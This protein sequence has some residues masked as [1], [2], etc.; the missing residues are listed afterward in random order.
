MPIDIDVQSFAELNNNVTDINNKVTPIQNMALNDVPA[1]S[2]NKISVRRGTVWNIEGE[3]VYNGQYQELG[4][5]SGEV[6]LELNM[7][8]SR[9]AV[10]ATITGYTFVTS[11]GA[12]MLTSHVYTIF[13]KQNSTGN[14]S[15]RWPYGASVLNMVG[16]DPNQI[17]AV[18]V[19]KLPNGKIF[20]KCE[21]FQGTV[22]IGS[23]I[24]EFEVP[25]I[26]FPDSNQA[27]MT[28][29][30]LK[31][32]AVAHGGS[33]DNLYSDWEIADDVLYTNLLFS[34]YGNTIDLYSIQVVL[35]QAG[36]IY[37][38]TRYGGDI[39]G[40]P[41]VSPWDEHACEVSGIDGDRYWDQ[42]VL[43]INADKY[44]WEGSRKIVDEKGW[45]TI[46]VLGDT[47][48]T[49]A[50]EKWAI[51]FDGS[52]DKLNVAD[53]A[54]INPTTQDFTLELFFS[55]SVVSSTILTIKAT[56]TGHRPYNISL[57]ATT[58]EIKISF[59]STTP[60]IYEVKSGV[61]PVVGKIYHV[62][63]VRSGSIFKIFVDGILKN[64]ATYAITLYSHSGPLQVGAT[65]DGLYPFNGKIYGMRFTNGI[66]RYS[67]DFQVDLTYPYFKTGNLW[68]TPELKEIATDNFV[69]KDD[70]EKT[71]LLINGNVG[72]VRDEASSRA[73]TLNGNA[74]LATENN[75]SYISFDGA[76]DFLTTPVGNDFSFNGDFTVE[77]FIRVTTNTNVP[78]FFI[79][80]SAASNNNRIMFGYYEGGW[81]IYANTTSVVWDANPSAPALTTDTIHHVALSRHS[82][83]FTVYVDGISVGTYTSAANAPSFAG[84]LLYIGRMRQANTLKDLNGRI[85]SYRISDF[86]RYTAN[87]TP[88]LTRPYF[89]TKPKVENWAE[90]SLLINALDL[91]VGSTD[92]RDS[93]GNAISLYGDTKVAKDTNGLEY[94]N[95]D[96]AGDYLAGT[97]PSLGAGLFTLEFFAFCKGASG[98][99][100]FDSR[101]SDLDTS[102]FSFYFRGTSNKITFGTSVGSTWTA[103]EGTVVFTAN[104]LYH[105]AVCRIDSTNFRVYVNGVL[106]N[107]FTFS[108]SFTRTSAR[109]G[110]NCNASADSGGAIYGAR[111]TVGKALYTSNFN[112]DLTN[113][114]FP[115]YDNALEDL[116]IDGNDYSKMTLATGVSKIVDKSGNR[117]E[118]IQNTA[119]S[120]PA[121]VQ[122]AQNG[123][124]AL[125]FDGVDDSLVVSSSNVFSGKTLGIFFV[126]KWSGTDQDI[127]SIH[128]GGNTAVLLESSN[129]S[130]RF[131]Y[132]NPPGIVG[133]I[134]IQSSTGTVPYG[135]V[136][137]GFARVSVSG[138]QLYMDEVLVAS[139]AAGVNF[140]SD[141]T[142]TLGFLGS[143][144]IRYLNGQ[145]LE[146]SFIPNLSDFWWKRVSGYLAHKWGLTDNLPDNHPYKTG[147]PM[148]DSRTDDYWY[149]TVLRINGTD[150]IR[151]T[152]IVDSSRYNKIT[153]Y[154]TLTV[155]VDASNRPYINFNG[156]WNAIYFPAHLYGFGASDFTI[157]M[158]V[159]FSGWNANASRLWNTNGDIYSGIDFSVDGSGGLCCYSS[160]TGSTWDVV[161]NAGFCQLSLN[162]LYHIAAVR[163]GTY[164][165]MFVNGTKYV[166][167]ATL[168]ATVLYTNTGNKS[169]GGQSPSYNR[170]LNGKL[171]SA[172]V[173]KGI[174]RYTENFEVDLTNP[175]FPNKTDSLVNVFDPFDDS[176]AIAYYL[177]QVDANDL[178][179]V[180]NGTPT[181]VNFSGTSATFDNLSLNN[182]IGV[183]AK[184]INNTD[185]YSISAWLRMD[186]GDFGG[187]FCQNTMGWNRYGIELLT[188]DGNVAFTHCRSDAVADN[189][190][191]FA[192]YDVDS[193]FH[194]FVATRN[195]LNIKIYKDGVLTQTNTL[196]H[197]T[198]ANYANAYIGQYV[199]GNNN[200]PQGIKTLKYLRLFNRELLAEEV[201]NLYSKEVGR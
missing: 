168:G 77:C 164:L 111:L 119:A 121:L 132:R 174:A 107:S 29:T 7:T 86:A 181:N 193:N 157:E 149:A 144:A 131:L 89:S 185:K 167:H 43:C 18:Y 159:E 74:A 97:M 80:P 94:I 24:K 169:I 184:P 113:P 32:Q 115:A 55:C 66:A 198:T 151:P 70:W 170:S 152:E 195:G 26:T 87:F 85:Y 11:F 23:V 64:E 160:S 102:G 105:I 112:V 114:Y 199:N 116:W 72:S 165:F 35:T 155:P 109:I 20:V 96:D 196:I 142:I 1:G 14:H 53:T 197:N 6:V 52:G 27:P 180:F 135:Q 28:F 95:F 51:N 173:T 177:L 189:R 158:F 31:T 33:L 46:S 156:G 19:V 79:T 188:Y 182:R 90:T 48:I 183:P 40:I 92:I 141:L 34:S 56:A 65:S 166:L 148:E 99:T 134:D 172:R 13:L 186:V 39:A 139:G 17:T 194:H 143:S 83:T 12:D 36:Q 37:M 22:E 176:S 140:S 2:N 125:N 68:W 62:A 133:G 179:G 161:S 21:A 42:T 50:S 41:M 91:P 147:F 60:T 162:T 136:Y 57:D 76:G 122:N 81:G 154:G 127:V 71:L 4:N 47:K 187:I 82:G 61:V 192:P 88:D 44:G 84:A 101:T 117:R 93:K 69:G 124:M 178:G 100:T 126:A 171:Y 146:L 10:L 163:Y 54:I 67:S 63:F 15:V 49:D 59:S 45:N 129:N 30:W 123:L 5:I 191:V 153:A 75:L 9:T 201:F 73:F 120:Q 103:Y 128:S 145:I 25:A 137:L 175:Y 190:S 38:R 58:K 3:E 98:F 78:I 118:A 110:T 106:D 16:P 200:T 104:T 108:N 150:I 130:F 8:T 138:N